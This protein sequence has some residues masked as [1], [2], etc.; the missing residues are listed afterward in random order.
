VDK[1]KRHA[2][3]TVK[4][5]SGKHN[6]KDRNKKIEEAQRVE[7]K[8]VLE[9]LDALEP[10]KKEALPQGIKALGTHLFT[11]EKFT[12]SGEP[13]KFK[14]QLVSHGSEQDALL[15]PDRSSPTVS[16]HAI[17]TCLAIAACNRLY[18]LR[19]IDVKGAFIQ[20]EMSGPPVYVKCTGK[21]RKVI[22]AM[23]THLQEFVGGDRVLY[24]KLN[25]AL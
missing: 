3:A 2:V 11:I 16:V 9:E 21:V 25:K 15:Y 13:E 19:K 8:Q 5:R 12:A 24:C 1:P 7:I 10:L 4:L 14:S 23:Y 17:M 22:L 6:S 18:T 20:T